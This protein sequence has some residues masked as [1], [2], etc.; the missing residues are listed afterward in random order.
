MQE[1]RYRGFDVMLLLSS[2]KDVYATAH[3]DRADGGMLF[4][5]SSTNS[6]HLING[7]NKEID[8]FVEKE[9]LHE[10]D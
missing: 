4:F 7:I 1:Y 9:K 3:A 2:K 5:S 8:D 6:R 10:E